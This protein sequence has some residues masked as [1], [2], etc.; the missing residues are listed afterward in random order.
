MKWESNG[1]P[2]YHNQF[3]QANL[4][5]EEIHETISI[6][7]QLIHPSVCSEGSREVKASQRSLHH[8]VI[9]NA[10]APQLSYKARVPHYER[11]QF[12]GCKIRVFKSFLNCHFLSLLFFLL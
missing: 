7:A 8:P 2:V 3:L 4:R 12:V 10:V 6:R 11:T 9:H 5:A 1:K